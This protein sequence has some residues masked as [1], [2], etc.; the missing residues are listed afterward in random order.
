MQRGSRLEKDVM[1]ALALALMAAALGAA[2]APQFYLHSKGQEVPAGAIE[3]VRADWSVTLTGHEPVSGTDVISLRR[4]GVPLPRW[5]REPQLLLVG[6]DRIVGQIVDCD[7]RGLRFRPKSTGDGDGIV[8]VPLSRADVLWL[9]PRPRER[10]ESDPRYPAL[11]GARQRDLLM[12]R[13][14]D[15]ISGDLLGIDG[16]AQKTRFQTSRELAIENAKIVAV[17]FNTQLAR[18]RTPKGIYARVVLTDGS[19]LTL[20]SANADAKSLTAENEFKAKLTIRW[21]DIV[22]LDLFGGA[23][24]YLSDLRPK[25]YEYTPFLS[26]RYPWIADRNVEDGP[27]VLRTKDGPAHFDKGLGLHSQCKLVYSL[28]GKYRTFETAIGLDEE[29]GKTGDAEMR[30]LIDGKQSNGAPRRLTHG[31]ELW[32]VRV[33]VSN[34]K[35]L[36]IE[37]NWGNGG[38]VGDAVDLGDARLI[39]AEPKR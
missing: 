21:E 1:S 37:V 28:D 26:E 5:P 38:H 19:R 7:G 27:I 8:R 10:G 29:L 12:L 3:R 4:V 36:T 14:G 17:G 22:A 25:K 35:E 20:Q 6:G 2:P 32:R 30:I 11:N 39:L 23:A 31:G 24:E 18:A 34:A 13:N 9:V 16:T 15:V 33:D